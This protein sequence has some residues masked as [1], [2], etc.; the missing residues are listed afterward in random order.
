[1]LLQD[2]EFEKKETSMKKQVARVKKRRVTTA[3][4]FEKVCTTSQCGKMKKK[5]EFFFIPKVATK[6]CE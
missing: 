4:A 1:M 2:N 3:D 6:R 5:E